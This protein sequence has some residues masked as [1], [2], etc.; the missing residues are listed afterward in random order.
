MQEKRIGCSSGVSGGRGHLWSAT[1]APGSQ[2]LCP[3][4]SSVHA[5]LRRPQGAVKTHR[6][7]LI[8]TLCWAPPPLW[9]RS[10]S[11]AQ[12]HRH[13]EH[14]AAL[15]SRRWGGS[16][17]GIRREVAAMGAQGEVRFNITEFCCSQSSK[18]TELGLQVSV[19]AMKRK[20]SNITILEK[21]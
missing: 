13:S 17:P 3:S 8:D 7:H 5:H 14:S 4:M 21:E 10:R 20:S 11:T 15:R 2:W 6:H 16:R 18:F 19:D 9:L 12:P 1:L